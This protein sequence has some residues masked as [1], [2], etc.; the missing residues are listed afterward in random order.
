MVVTDLNT[1]GAR[2]R[3]EVS[4]FIVKQEGQSPRVAEKVWE[5][6]L[7]TGSLMLGALAGMLAGLYLGRRNGQNDPALQPRDWPVNIAHRGGRGSP[8]KTPSR[9]SG[10]ASGWA[11]AC[12]SSTC[13]PPPTG[14]SS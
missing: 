2:E 9:V 1:R 12:W 14:A 6:R 13:T 11:L 10:K 3:S 8:P 5:V 7:G 4:N